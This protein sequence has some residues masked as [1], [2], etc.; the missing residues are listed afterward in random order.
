M[1]EILYREE[2]SAHI[3]CECE[4]LFSLRNAYMGCFFLDPQDIKNL[5]LR[6]NWN[7]SKR[8]GLPWPSKDYGAQMVCLKAQV[9]RDRK[10]SNPVTNLI[11]CLDSM[12]CF[13]FYVKRF[14]K[15]IVL[16]VVQAQNW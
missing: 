3:L 1:Q 5:S 9:H 12:G 6:A 11:Y 10:G 13:E 4:A 8:T 16:C 2:T 14:R 15:G 7:I